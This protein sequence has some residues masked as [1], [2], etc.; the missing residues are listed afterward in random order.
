MN[1]LLEKIFA[2]RGSVAIASFDPTEYSITTHTH[3]YLGM[4]IHQDDFIITFQ[5]QKKKVVKILKSNINQI[6]VLLSFK[7]YAD[8]TR[9]TQP[10]P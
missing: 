6:A 1:N 10:H 4:I 7:N 3:E 8:P 5:N 9:T 2:C